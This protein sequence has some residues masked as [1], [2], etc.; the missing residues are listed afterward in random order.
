MTKSIVP[1]LKFSLN[2]FINPLATYPSSSSTILRAT[3]KA[4]TVD[5]PIVIIGT[6]NTSHIKLSFNTSKNLERNLY[7]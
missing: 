5:A 2:A 3:V 7:K 4:A 1:C 6:Q